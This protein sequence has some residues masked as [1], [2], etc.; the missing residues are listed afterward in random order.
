[1]TLLLNCDPQ[2]TNH[3]SEEE[4]EE[5][6]EKVETYFWHYLNGQNLSCLFPKIK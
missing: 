3:F 5:E 6:E 2:F 1:M 4:E